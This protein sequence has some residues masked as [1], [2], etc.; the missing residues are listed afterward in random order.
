M[1]VVVVASLKHEIA[2]AEDRVRSEK[3]MGEEKVTMAEGESDS[4]RREK[5]DVE[6]RLRR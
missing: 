2:D 4:L 5:E 1:V 6:R 3:K